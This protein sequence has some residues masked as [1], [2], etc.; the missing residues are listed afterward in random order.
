MSLLALGVSHKNAPVSVREG[1]A[2]PSAA[3][4]PALASLAREEEIEEAAILSTCNRTEI[5][6]RLQAESDRGVV[7]WLAR[8]HG[9]GN[10]Q[11]QPYLYRHP[12][13][14]A[15]R[16]VMRVASGLDS[17]VIGETQVLGQL[18]SAY[19]VAVR[20]GTVGALLNRLFQNSFAVAKQVRS[21]TAIG[22]N[23][24]SVAAVAVQLARRIFGNLDRATALL[25]GAGETIE[26]AV[27][28]LQDEGLDRIVV[29]NRSLERAQ[30]LA[31]RHDG[32]AVRLVDLPRYLLEADIVITATGSP[33]CILA[34]DE[35]ARLVRKRRHRPVFL[36]DLAV[37]RD[38]DPKAGEIE[39]VYLYNVDDLKQ[40]IDRNLFHRR[41][42]A[43]EAEKIIEN[44]VAHFMEWMRMRVAVPEIHGLHRNAWETR[45]NVLSSAEAK[46]RRGA[47]PVE[48][49]REATRSLTGKLLHL[50]TERLR[51][52]AAHSERRVAADDVSDASMQTDADD[53][54]PNASRENCGLE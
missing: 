19:E 14:H 13:R 44:R 31:R 36:V 15:V 51:A 52:T 5:Y 37:P 1:L 12:E 10:G 34:R 35:I 24:V 20:S 7:N 8:Y 46:L 29:A 30:S 43:V 23:P 21:H 25:I 22:H 48:V 2:L 32:H 18:K 47:D 16:H 40:I 42:A 33:N 41:Q 28:H 45:D 3:V 26:I 9:L 53:S 4:A 27:R 49:V 6:C 54:S 38:V 39:D 50:P 11:V 17:M